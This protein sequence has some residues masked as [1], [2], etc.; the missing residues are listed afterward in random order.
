MCVLMRAALLG[1][2]TRESFFWVIHNQFPGPLVLLIA[3]PA[4][5]PSPRLWRHLLIFEFVLLLAFFP[6]SWA[7]VTLRM[8]P[9]IS[10]IIY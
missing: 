9:L 8:G 2:I 4:F 3:E 10:S 1:G 6:S 5:V 7:P